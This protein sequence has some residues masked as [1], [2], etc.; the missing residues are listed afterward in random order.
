MNTLTSLQQWLDIRTAGLQ[1]WWQ[2]R[3]ERERQ[4]LKLLA[5]AGA[6]FVFFSVIWLPLTQALSS[7]ES[8]YLSAKQT[9]DWMSANAPVIRSS[10]KDGTVQSIQGDWV[11]NINQSA[12]AAGLAL[13]GFTPQGSN[14][15][16]VTLDKQHF[17]SVMSW[18]N[19]L[20]QKGIFPTTLV[21]NKS[22]QP[23]LVDVRVSLS[24]N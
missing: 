17:A 21:I 10:A 14:A 4:V 11:M 23:G 18:L 3:V 22:T 9:Y 1:R 5:V 13:K 12:S 2:Q 6:V 20:E 15:V 16:S 7:A 8:R 19:Q 24:G